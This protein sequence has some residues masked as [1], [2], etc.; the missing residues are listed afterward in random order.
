MDIRNS[1][2]QTLRVFL[3]EVKFFAAENLLLLVLVDLV[4]EFQLESYQ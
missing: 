2:Q 1:S 4:K 3:I